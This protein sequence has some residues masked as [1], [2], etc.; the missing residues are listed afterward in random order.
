MW[1]AE[2]IFFAKAISFLSGK[3]RVAV[4]S[5]QEELS[6][7]SRDSSPLESDKFA[8]ITD[9]ENTAS[10][11]G[12]EA[13]AGSS[14]KLGLDSLPVDST[15]PFQMRANSTS[16][17]QWVNDA[18]P[19][20][21][22]YCQNS[23]NFNCNKYG[24]VATGAGKYLD[25]QVNI[26]AASAPDRLDKR[27]LVVFF[28]RNSHKRKLGRAMVNCFG[29]CSCTPLLLDGWNTDRSSELGTASVEVSPAVTH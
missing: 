17:W 3:Q 21:G 25:F 9:G 5:Q 7:D 11:S 26:S 22:D 2:S 13:D 4:S 27:S 23:K 28:R 19:S 24:Y 20:R 18:L 1:C 8:T 6:Q 14:L 29:G 16:D 15:G 12:D 10:S